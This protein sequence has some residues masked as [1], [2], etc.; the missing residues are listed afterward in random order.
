MKYEPVQGVD[1]KEK[2]QAF[3]DKHEAEYNECRK[4]CPL[5][6]LECEEANCVAW[7]KAKVYLSNPSRMTLDQ[8]IYNIKPGY[9]KSPLITGKIESV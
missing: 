7:V 3:L 1:S 6:R 8:D 9:C 2:A 4:Q 5:I